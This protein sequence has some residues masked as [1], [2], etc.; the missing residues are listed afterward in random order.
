MAP[1]F[2]IVHAMCFLSG[3]LRY[4]SIRPQALAHLPGGCRPPQRLSFVVQVSEALS[5]RVDVLANGTIAWMEGA[6]ITNPVGTGV[7][8]GYLS[9]DS[10]SFVS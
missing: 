8:G 9:L 7:S 2:T 6:T 5:A 10:I 3:M 1:R 4:D